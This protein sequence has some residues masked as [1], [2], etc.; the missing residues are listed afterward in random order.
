MRTTIVAG[1]FLFAATGLVGAAETHPSARSPSTDPVRMNDHFRDAREA[2]D[3]RRFGEASRDIRA[4][5]DIVRQEA[6][7]ATG[8]DK[9][10]LVAAAGDLRALASRVEKG[11]VKDVAELNSEFARADNRLAAHY[12][13][14]ASESWG[15]QKAGEA[16][17]ALGTA[18]A[19]FKEATSW[20]GEKASEAADTARTV[21]GKLVQGAGWVPKEVGDAIAG[22]GHGI[23]ALGQKIEPGRSTAGASERGTQGGD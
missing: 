6:N 5:A 13:K 20:T 2:F 3:G 17:G 21:A 14:M 22:L 15:H 9:D 8:P 1:L 10:G 18:A 19:Y 16:G 7:E 12:Q 11:S 4:G 23:R